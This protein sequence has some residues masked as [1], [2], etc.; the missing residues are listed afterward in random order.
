MYLIVLFAF[1]PIWAV[2][3]LFKEKSSECLAG[4]FCAIIMLFGAAIA[5][6]IYMVIA[7]VCLYYAPPLH[8]ML[9]LGI[10]IYAMSYIPAYIIIF[11]KMV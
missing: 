10:G 9:G 3:S 1:F 6:A 2:I 5:F 8:K 4:F 7:F 11:T